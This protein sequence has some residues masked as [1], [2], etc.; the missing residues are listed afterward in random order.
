[1][2]ARAT[3]TGSLVD[4]AATEALS[5]MPSRA[6]Y[7]LAHH[8]R[9]GETIQF[10][11]TATLFPTGVY[12]CGDGYVA[13]MSTPQ[14]LQE[15]LDVIDDDDLRAA[16]AHPDALSHAETAEAVDAAVYP[17]LLTRTRAEIT[18]AAQTRGWPL[19]GV[20][21]PAEV[22]AADHLRQR[23]FWVHVDDPV[24]GALDLPGPPAR[25]AEGGFSFRR[26]PPRLG[27][28][29]AEVAAEAEAVREGAP[30]TEA[31][32]TPGMARVREA[33]LPLA[34]IR[35][36][37]LTA[38]WSGPY[39]TMLLGDF[40]AEV[41]RVENPFVLPPTTKGYQAR[42]ASFDNLGAL[43]SMYGFPVPDRPDR[44]WNRHA[45]NNSLARN[46]LSVT[47]DTR[48]PEGHEL[49]MRLV[50]T[51]D[52]FIDNFKAAGLTAIGISISELQARNP[53]LV[54]V[55]LPPTG[56]T[57]DWAHY[58][59]FGA[60]FDGLSGLAWLC[61]HR[62]TNPLMTPATTY[63]DGASGPAAAFATLAALHYRARTG[64]GQVVELVQM[65][66]IVQQLGDVMVDC[67]LGVEPERIGNRDPRVRA[68]GPLRLPGRQPLAGADRDD[69]RR[70]GRP[71]QGHGPTRAGR[72]PALRRPGRA[73]G[74]PRRARRPRGR[75]GG[76]A[77]S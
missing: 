7:L 75:L 56:T 50:E 44:P 29:D 24:H 20:N 54:I 63:M 58:T 8:Y 5:T 55:R 71:R 31:A 51:C 35:V 38:V 68:A 18:R 37:D 4:C 13:M 14:Q 30:A 70:V 42:P 2:Y 76:R 36:A 12:P 33:G 52:V 9:G 46:K 28:D 74:P 49:L 16:F 22:L 60:Q 61:G 45:M 62:D 77:G 69:R 57:G 48:R 67:E 11:A 32:D 17:W 72:R 34:G 25:F 15:M 65:E 41:I 39:A 47:I 23:G 21:L 73:H 1:M 19:A 53:R 10:T 43:G 26:R 66:N 64:R 59:G 40:G 6:C 27:E 3:G